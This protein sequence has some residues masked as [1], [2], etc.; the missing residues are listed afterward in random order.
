[1]ILID[2]RTG[3][4][5]TAYL[6][7]A[8]ARLEILNSADYAF[9]GQ[10]NGKPVRIGV[11]RKRLTS[12]DMVDSLVSGRFVGEQLPKL[13][14][15]YGLVFLVVEGLFRPASDRHGLELYIGDGWKRSQ[16]TFNRLFQFLIGLQVQTGVRVLMSASAI[17][18]AVMVMSMYDFFQRP[19]HTSLQGVW[20][21]QEHPEYRV[22]LA[23]RIATQLPGVGWKKA[24][25]ISENWGLDGLLAALSSGEAEV[26][27]SIPGV[28]AKTATG[29]VKYL[30]D[31][32]VKESR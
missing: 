14:A 13:L 20:L 26:W 5:E 29:V 30:T 18:T 22:S 23:T 10:L 27:E 2:S 12:G 11:E 19:E 17:Q 4:K 32:R 6:F 9:E 16:I 15:D 28:G 7:G 31:E 24:K 21:G 1:M 8:S 3:S 25:W